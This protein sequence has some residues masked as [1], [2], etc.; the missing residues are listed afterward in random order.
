MSFNFNSASYPLRESKGELTKKLFWAM[1]GWFYIAACLGFILYIPMNITFGI[2]GYSESNIYIIIVAL[3]VV[4]A[5]INAYRLS[6]KIISDGQK[7]L[8]EVMGN[9]KSPLFYNYSSQAP[10]ALDPIE[11]K[12]SA[13]HFNGS[14]RSRVAHVIKID[15]ITQ[16]SALGSRKE[17]VVSLEDF[18]AKGGKA[19]SIS[20][21]LN[22]RVNDIDAPTIFIPM[23]SEDAISWVTLINKSIKKEEFSFGDKPKLYPS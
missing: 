14:K 13:Y 20:S 18:A 6:S 23:G 21:G 3:M 11:R 17:M 7:L 1:K 10:I 4:P 12:I 9:L 8:P 19:R 5:L 22:L 16:V 15:D 2:M